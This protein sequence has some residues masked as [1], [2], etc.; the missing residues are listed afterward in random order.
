MFASS[1][2]AA[3]RRDEH[4]GESC[5]RRTR[6]VNPARSP[7]SLKRNAGPKSQG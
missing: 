4:S 6:G 5:S 3:V 2:C 7:Y 1:Y